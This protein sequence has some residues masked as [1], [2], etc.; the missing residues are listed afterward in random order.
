MRGF[1]HE[2]QHNES[3]EWYTPPKIFEAL[4]ARFDLDPASPGADK[5]PWIPAVR[6]CTIA[7]DG[8]RQDWGGARVWLNPP[9]GADT[10]EW[11]RKFIR[12]DCSGLMLVFSRTDTAWFHELAVHATA[13]CFVRKRIQFVRGDGYVGGGSGA[14]SLLLAKGGE[15]EDALTRSRLGFVCRGRPQ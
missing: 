2:S 1:S 8:L 9:Y 7:D 14:A 15:F 12:S 3:K 5:V 11:M 10:A 6:H 13:M 4:G